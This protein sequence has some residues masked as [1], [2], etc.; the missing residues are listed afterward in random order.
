[1]PK[2]ACDFARS[3][4]SVSTGPPA[5]AAGDAVTGD[6]RRHVGELGLLLG[7]VEVDEEELA[8]LQRAVARG[9]DGH[10]LDV[11][12]QRVALVVRARDGLDV[13]ALEVA[14]RAALAAVLA[15]ERLA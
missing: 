15:A 8:R 12:R 7:A 5:D 14:V 10:E 1:M 2:F 3:S 11:G 4:S 13:A 6:E 9:G